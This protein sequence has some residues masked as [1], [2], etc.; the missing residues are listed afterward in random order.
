M[1]L[2]AESIDPLLG[3][4][5]LQG[6]PGILNMMAPP[7]LHTVT[8]DAYTFGSLRWDRPERAEQT[9]EQAIGESD[10]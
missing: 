7:Q 4:L 10:R 8:E 6:R 2:W 9:P 3:M 5:T 1:T